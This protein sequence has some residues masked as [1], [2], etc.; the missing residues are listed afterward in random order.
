MKRTL[1]QLVI[2]KVFLPIE[3]WFYDA[4]NG[5]FSPMPLREYEENLLFYHGK[6]RTLGAIWRG[7]WNLPGTGIPRIVFL[8][9]EVCCAFGKHEWKEGSI[10]DGY[11][12]QIYCVHCGKDY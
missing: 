2:Q 10:H 5:K 6:L 9:H 1:K 11:P 4:E 12:R 7:I 3:N 8:W